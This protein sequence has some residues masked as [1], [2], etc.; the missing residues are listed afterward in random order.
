M[1]CQVSRRTRRRRTTIASSSSSSS[2][3]V[4]LLPF[5]AGLRSG[6]AAGAATLASMG[7]P[8]AASGFG[9]NH[10]YRRSTDST[11]TNLQYRGRDVTP[12]YS[13][14]QERASTPAFTSQSFTEHDK[15]KS[16]PTHHPIMTA[17][18]VHF[19]WL[20]SAAFRLSVMRPMTSIILL[21]PSIV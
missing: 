3:S 16:P 20:V 13:R 6:L 19:V 11:I 18:S 15:A 7:S 4:P 9:G 5:E 14:P 1:F 2:A 8:A 21:S 17:S 10:T 12:S